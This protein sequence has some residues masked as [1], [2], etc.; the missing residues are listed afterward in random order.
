MRLS[1][2][3]GLWLVALSLV[4]IGTFGWIQLEREEEDLYSAVERELLLVAT[5]VRSA[6]E[7]ATRDG[8]EADIAELLRQL[9]HQD[10]EFD[11]FVFREGQDV[12]TRSLNGGS[13]L[14]DARELAASSQR[15]PSAR[16]RRLNGGQLG[17]VAPIALAGQDRGVVVLFRAPHT[18]RADLRDERNATLLSMVTLASILSGGVWLVLQLRLQRPISHMVSVVQRVAAGELSA[19][20]RLRGADDLQAFGREFDAMV[21]SLERAR[22][23]LARE[24]EKREQMESEMLRANRLAIVGELAATLAHE[25]GSPLQVLGGR[26]RDMIEHD[27]LPKE[28]GRNAEIIVQQVERVDQIVQSFLDVARRKAPSFELLDLSQVVRDVVELIE[29]QARRQGVHIRVDCARRLTVRADAAQLQQVLLNLLQNALRASARGQ[30]VWVRTEPSSFRRIAPGP[31]LASVSLLV[32]DEG[33]GLPEGD[34]QTVFQP[35]FTAWHRS[36][37]Q[38]LGTGLGLSVVRTIMAEHEG[39]VRA[40]RRQH[41]TG[42]RFVLHFPVAESSTGEAGD[43][44]A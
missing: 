44:S 10:P 5:A 36:T 29:S 38:P 27:E 19:R 24:T 32:E 22:F 23:E 21:E 6:V 40:E 15:D 37:T 11:V 43:E 41:G 3:L 31:V 26:A 4:V 12:L 28:L 2:S 18:L 1:V 13:N 39:M 34:P 33:S 14:V 17:V 20:T 16:I 30:E 42:T 7:N 8:Q 35:F 9:E 25:L